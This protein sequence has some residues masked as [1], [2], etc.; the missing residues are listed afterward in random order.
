MS[1]A[2]GNVEP[3]V[4]DPY[5]Y[6][7]HDDP[8][9]TYARLREE[10]PLYRNDERGF[11]AL[12]RHADVQEG[13]R[14][15]GDLSSS[16][17]VSLDPLATSPDAHRTMSFLAMD[18]PRHGHMRALVSKG[19]T[20][21][22]VLDLEPRIREITRS[23]VGPLVEVGSFDTIG[24]LA[25]KIPMDVISELIGVP[26]V[27]RD[28]IRR[29]SDLVV[30]REEGVHDVPPEGI[31]A[32]LGLVTY[33][34][35]LLGDRRANPGDDLASA[36]CDAEIDGARLSD[37]DIIGFL[38]L[39]GVAGNETTTKL[40][41]HALWWAWRNPD[42]RRI[43]WD[44]PAR[45]SDWVEETLRYDASSQGLA[46]T[47]T[48]DL[49]LH[50][51]T[52]PAGD[53]VLLLVGAANRDPRVFAN[54]DDFDISRPENANTLSFG[55]GRHFCLGA[56]LARLETRVVLEEIVTAV[57][58]YDIDAE[59]TRRVHSINVRGMSHMPMTVEAR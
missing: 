40:L 15:S 20:P 49:H 38:F 19:F 55:F 1:G 34:A 24:D 36:L 22:R 51:G 58:D 31:E 35:D 9:P 44:D 57:A 28:E 8:Y 14:N 43:I 10:A 47:A 5:A 54:P 12:S 30:H 29:L 4:Y 56:S 27:D 7:M 41:G 18:P 16:H 17:G 6:A 32:A 53:R 26:V 33:Y 37:N 11:W 25:G 13:F 42:Q 45:V 46:R 52:I 23:Y 21:R 59:R 3:V 2:V 50:G 48:T 39:M